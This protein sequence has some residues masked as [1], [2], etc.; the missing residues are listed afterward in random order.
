MPLTVMAVENMLEEGRS[1]VMIKNWDDRN[2]LHRRAEAPPLP[3]KP[4]WAYDRRGLFTKQHKSQL[5]G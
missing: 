4:V 2:G 1:E 5:T 3:G